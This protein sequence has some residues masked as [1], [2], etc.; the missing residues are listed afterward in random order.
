MH[1]D[2]E[3]PMHQVQGVL[4]RAQELKRRRKNLFEENKRKDYDD[5]TVKREKLVGGVYVRSSKIAA[6]RPSAVSAVNL[7]LE[8]NGIGTRPCMGTEAVVSKFEELKFLIAALVDLRR[9]L[10]ADSLESSKSTVNVSM[11][12]I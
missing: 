10:D 3:L 11:C 1:S 7:I 9:V 8:E 5:F 6:V 4:D 2:H 12:L